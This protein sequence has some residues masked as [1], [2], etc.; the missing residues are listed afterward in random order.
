QFYFLEGITCSG[1]SSSKGM[2]Y[3]LQPENFIFDVGATGIIPKDSLP[4]NFYLGYLNTKLIAYIINCLNPTVNTSEGDVRRIPFVEPTKDQIGIV[5]RVVEKNIKNKKDIYRYSLLDINK[6]NEILINFSGLTPRDRVKSYLDFENCLHTEILINEAFINKVIFKIYNL[7]P[8]DEL[9]ILNSEGLPV[10]DYPVLK[11]AKDAFLGQLQ[12]PLTEV[13]EHIVNIAVTTFDEQQI[14]EIKEGFSTLYQSNNDLEEF[15]IRHQVNPINVWYWFRETNTVPA[16]RASEIALEF[17]ADA[18][19]T[20]LL[21]DDDSIIPLVGLPGEEALSQRLEQHCLQNGFTAAQYMQLDSLLGR[22]IN[23]Y[24]EHHFFN[25]LSNHLNLFM[26]LPKTPFI[27]HLSSGQHQ[28][29]EAYIL[30]YKWNRDS[31]FKLKSQY[32]SQRVQNLEYRQIQ[33]QDI[34]T[35]QAQTEKEKIRLQLHEIETFK[36]KID[37]LIAEGYDP[38][39]DDGVGKNIA[40]LQKK[41]LLR[42]EVLKSAGRNSQLEKYLNADW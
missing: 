38:K 35:A 10:G 20:L 21:Q 12:N 27:W 32:I 13:S 3:R 26:Y 41:G 18:I 2:S 36:T 5:A 19:R 37:E 40:P 42:A 34:N 30:I 28:G 6:S 1:R 17:L 15:C 33:L 8:D 11:E 16:A 31:L 39:L 22:S 9:M 24:L 29:F 25:Q 23:E 14:R 4:L 7:S